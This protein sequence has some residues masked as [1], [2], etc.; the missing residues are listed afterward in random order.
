VNAERQR[1]RRLLRPRCE[2]HKLKYDPL[3]SFEPICNLVHTL[4]LIAVS[5]ASP[6][7]TLAD[8]I[9]AAR[10]KPGDLTLASDG[11]ATGHQ[12]AI[13]MFKRATNINMIFV[14]YPGGAPVVN[15]VL[16]EHVTSLLL[17]YPAV[18]EQLKAGNLRAL[19]TT[20][21][22]R[23]EALPEVPTVAE[24]GYKDYEVDLWWGLLAPMKTPKERVSQLAGWFAAAMQVPEVR[25]QLVAQ[26]LY[27][28]GV[29]GVDFAAFI[30]KQYDDYGRVIR[31]ANIKAE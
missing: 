17:N 26:G 15:A 10:A 30:R 28:V 1:H 31:E 20:W 8:L 9:T 16:G 21:R 2:R 3:T 12:I 22:T 14:P 7:R 29:C 13:E 24:S 6:Y 23:G 4:P 19:A 27:P 5:S 25:A 18:A 11:P